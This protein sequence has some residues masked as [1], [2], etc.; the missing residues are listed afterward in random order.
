[1]E[2][3]RVFEFL[4]LRAN[5]PREIRRVNPGATGWTENVVRHFS[6]RLTNLYDDSMNV[7]GKQAHDEAA[8]A[9]AVEAFRSMLD[10]LSPLARRSGVSTATVERLVQAYQEEVDALRE[11]GWFKPSRWPNFPGDH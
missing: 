1:E 11:S 10:H 6:S 4:G 2:W 5:P 9:A 3:R 7:V 8:T